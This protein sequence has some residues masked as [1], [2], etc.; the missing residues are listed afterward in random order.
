MPIKK[1]FLLSLFSFAIWCA[2]APNTHAQSPAPTF[3]PVALAPLQR[4]S[5]I[6]LV[7]LTLDAQIKEINGHTIITA[8]STFKL[9]N[10][11]RLTDTQVAMGFPTWAGDPFAFD[12]A[13]LDAFAVTV[14]NK[15]ITLQ[16]TR[17]DLKIGNTVRTVDWFTF[18]LPILGDEKRTVQMDFQQDLGDNAMPTIHYGLITANGWK[19]SVGSARLTVAFPEATTLEQITATDPPNPTFDGNAVTWLLQKNEALSNPYVTIIKPSV[20]NDLLVRRRA[21]R[22]NPNDAATRTALGNLYLTLAQYDTPKS[23]SLSAQGIA[24]LESAIRADPGFKSARQ[25][26]A[27]LY[28]TRAGPATGTR[29]AAYVQL[30]AQNWDVL[31]ASDTN[32]RKQLAE[33]Y[34]YLGM[35]AQTRGAFADA[36]NYFDKAAATAPNG[37]GPLYT[38]E[39]MNAQR[40][41]LNLAWIRNALDQNDTTLALARART[42]FGDSFVKSF[43]VPAFYATRAEITTN[44]NIRVI[45]FSLVRFGVSTEE[46]QSTL[47]SVVASAK[48]L[49]IETRITDN[50]ATLSFAIPFEDATQVKTRQASLAKTLDAPEWALARTVLSPKEL[51]WTE[52]KQLIVETMRYQENAD[53]AGACASF[54]AQ[55]QPIAQNL[56]ALENL[57]DEE[58]QVKRTL[59][60]NAQRGWMSAA[61]LSR[62]VYHAGAEE[63]P[64][65]PCGT[66]EIASSPVSIQPLG[67]AGIFIALMIGSGSLIFVARK[68]RRRG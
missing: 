30:A 48:N 11:D 8:T 65:E 34:F 51:V 28:E 16:P 68:T 42:Q 7:A 33:D 52:N 9:H 14:D 44:S 56:S 53:F 2:L 63:F 41:A 26:L 27:A 31:A 38:L 50:N 55:A 47:N 46:W 19:N 58:S 21:A 10:T 61:T 15:K 5:A 54:N 3:I 64:V 62:V 57:N 35:D 12:P 17:A 18:T 49:G 22:Q 29:R 24:E 6:E 20:W 66:R 40:R 60:Q 1:I 45:N 59:L 39:R 13:R 36:Q 67:Y 4:D 23:D 32:A 25:S 43:R 37:A